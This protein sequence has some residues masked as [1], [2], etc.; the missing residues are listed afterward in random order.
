MSKIAIDEVESV[1]L[2]QKVDP[3]KVNQIV[4]DLEK[5]VEE[6][7]E[8]RKANAEERQKWEHVIVLNDKE[9][10]LKGKEIAGWVVQQPEGEDANLIIAKIEKA[11][12][13][14]NEASKRKKNCINTLTEIFEGLKA[15]FLE[16][17]IRI[18]T[19]E[20]TRVLIIN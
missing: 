10:L 1:L 18:K 11:A 17:K 3:A 6:L 19:K 9:G 13:T 5:I 20:L 12:K 7:T 4:K 8:D 16:K 15:K 2:Q 14:Q